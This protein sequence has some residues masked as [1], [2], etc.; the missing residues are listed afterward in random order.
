ML[1]V[2]CVNFVGNTFHFNIDNL[3]NYVVNE[4]RT[5]YV[6]DKKKQGTLKCFDMRI[7]LFMVIMVSMHVIL[8]Q[9]YKNVTIYLSGYIT[10]RRRG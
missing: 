7:S 3:V 10:L 5:K 4:W 1:Y 6:Y 8:L 9:Y 2:E